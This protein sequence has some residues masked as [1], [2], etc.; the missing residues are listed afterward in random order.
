MKFVSYW[1]RAADAARTGIVR[2]A[3]IHGLNGDAQIADLLAEGP[4]GLANAAADIAM[5]PLEIVDEA[6]S[7]VLVPIPS[8]PSVRDF[9]SFEAHV[10]TSMAAIG[11]EVSPFWYEAPTF[12]FSNPAAVRGPND[13]IAISPGSN[14]FDYELEFAAVIGKPGSDITVA[15]AGSHVAGYVLLCDWS[16]RDL[17]E[18]EMTIGLGPVKGKDTATTIGPYFVTADEFEVF[19]K[20]NGFALQMTTSV[21]GRLYSSGNAA[22]LYWS[23][24]QMISYA[25]RGTTLVTGDI[26]GSGTVGTGCIL[27]LA[28]VHG[29]EAYPW[30][31]AGDQVEVSVENLGSFTTEILG[32]HEP[33]PLS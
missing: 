29:P 23:F 27:E 26:I 5:N 33:A 4:L 1:S 8:P 12:Y 7:K 16:A 18:Q 21:N 28:R 11:R 9:M 30:L 2:D 3:W 31:K 17:Q 32:G 14:A 25:S 19:R 15:D 13:P 10:V 6:S 20:D 22:D 24:E